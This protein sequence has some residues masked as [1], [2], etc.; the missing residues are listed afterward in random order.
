MR[1]EKIQHTNRLLA[2][3]MY[4][5]NLQDGITFHTSDENSLQV[6]EH[7]YLKGKV[8]A[9]HSHQPVKVDRFETMQEV[10]VIKKGK[11]KVLLYTEEGESIGEK[12][13]QSGDMILLIAGGHGFEMLEDAQF[14]EIKQGP[15]LPESRKRLEIKE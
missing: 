10:L 13:L 11:V 4:A 9:P 3:I 12:I 5:G 2:M 15:Y 1:I 8:I 6:G 7:S 14:I